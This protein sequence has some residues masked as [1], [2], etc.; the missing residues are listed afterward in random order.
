MTFINKM[1]PYLLKMFFVHHQQRRRLGGPAT[2]FYLT[3]FSV[4]GSKKKSEALGYAP[5]VCFIVFYF[6][7]CCLF[8]RFQK[9]MSEK[10]AYCACLHEQHN[11]LWL[12]KMPSS[13]RI[14]IT[15]RVSAFDA[16]RQ[17][18]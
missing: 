12:Q 4:Q 18:S 11:R 15:G 17:P 6:T 10:W 16:G 9:V 14:I 8:G 2:Q 1:K 13:Q 3:D 7:F 5:L